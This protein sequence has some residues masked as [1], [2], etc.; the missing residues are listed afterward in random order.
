MKSIELSE[1]DQWLISRHHE[2]NFGSMV[3]LPVRRSVEYSCESPL[4]HET[5]MLLIIAWTKS[6]GCSVRYDRAEGLFKLALSDTHLRWTRLEITYQIRMSRHG[7]C[8]TKF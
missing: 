6:R 4:G 1:T 7:M 5:E 3:R 8:G 2:T